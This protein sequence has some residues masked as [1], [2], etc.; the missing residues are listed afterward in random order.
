MDVFYALA[1]PRRRR[2]IGLL[3][4]NGKLSATEI[5]S[6]FDVTAQAISQH[7]RVLLD[8]NLVRM[9]KHAQQ[10]IYRLNPKSISEVEKW[11]KLTERIWNQRL[12]RLDGLLEAEKKKNAKK[13]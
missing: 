3:A 2:I 11:V 1:E 7:L 5:C 12:D 4:S 9:E 10:R 8:A 13:R 6:R